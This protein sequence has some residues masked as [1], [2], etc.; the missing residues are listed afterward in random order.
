MPISTTTIQ[1]VDIENK[2]RN[3]D[4]AIRWCFAHLLEAVIAQEQ[5]IKELM[6]NHAKMVET[7]ALDLH[8]K[9]IIMDRLGKIEKRYDNT[10]N[11]SFEEP[12]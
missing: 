2:L 12:S 8:A 3:H 5:L 1:L 4:P 9:K 7:V 11:V 6:D 10:G